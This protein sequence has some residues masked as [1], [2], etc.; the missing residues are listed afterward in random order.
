M[1]MKFDK[2]LD[3]NLS[4]SAADDQCSEQEQYPTQSGPSGLHLRGPDAWKSEQML[5]GRSENTHNAAL[6][7]S[8]K[9]NLKEQSAQRQLEMRSRNEF[10]DQISNPQ[11]FGVVYDMINRK[12]ELLDNQN[13]LSMIGKRPLGNRVIDSISFDGAQIGAKPPNCDTPLEALSKKQS[14]MAT[15]SHFFQP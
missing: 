12:H 2:D 3:Q 6:S 7:H 13:K 1:K 9:Q 8:T 4:N 10:N 11:S 5:G 14:Q 15:K